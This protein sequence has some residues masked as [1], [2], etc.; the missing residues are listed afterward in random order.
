MNSEKIRHSNVNISPD[1]AAELFAI[2]VSGHKIT[3]IDIG[4][5]KEGDCASLAL[6]SSEKLF[7]MCAP[8]FGTQQLATI[9]PA[10]GLANLFGV[11]VPGLSVMAMAFA[12]NGVLYAVGDGEH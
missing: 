8:L 1:I 2:E 5:T 3:T 12:P 7:S 11:P 6:S 10:T 9:D 4:P